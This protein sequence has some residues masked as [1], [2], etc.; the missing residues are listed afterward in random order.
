LSQD[1]KRE[2]LRISG[3]FEEFF[4]IQL[5]K[6]HDGLTYLLMAIGIR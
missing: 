5:A 6:D 4:S 2:I 1:V 3:I